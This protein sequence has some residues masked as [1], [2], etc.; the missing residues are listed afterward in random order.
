M[1]A[2]AG[3]PTPPRR[4]FLS[5]RPSASPVPP[6]PARLESTAPGPLAE[7][8]RPAPRLTRRRRRHLGQGLRRPPGRGRPG[9]GP[10]PAGPASA[11]G[12]GEH[13]EDEQAEAEEHEQEIGRAS[14]RE[15]VEDAVDAVRMT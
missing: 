3:G 2:A 10:T 1:D 6:H 14:C 15:R 11:V 12:D 7:K 5:M 4:W 8:N 13:E 9:P